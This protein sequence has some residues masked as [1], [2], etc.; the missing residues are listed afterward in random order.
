MKMRD[1]HQGEQCHTKSITK[2]IDS[3]EAYGHSQQLDHQFYRERVL[4]CL[5][6]KLRL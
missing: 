5:P 6:R 4:R 2:S 3:S 1:G